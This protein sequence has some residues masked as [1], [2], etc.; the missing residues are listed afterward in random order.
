M[1]FVPVAEDTGLVVALGRQVL[2]RACADARRWSELRPDAPPLELAVNVSARELAQRD[3]AAYVARVLQET[4]LDPGTLVLEITET[5]LMGNIDRSVAALHR[6]RDLGVRIAVDD[7]GT[8][9]ASLGYLRR[10]PIDILKVEKSFI[11]GLGDDGD[12][13]VFAQAIVSLGKSL[14]LVVVAEGVET[15]AHLREIAAI[16]CDVAQ[17]YYFSRPI[18]GETILSVFAA[19]HW[20]DGLPV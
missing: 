16:G 15:E 19:P 18:D 14:G 7:F 11:Q 8:G 20:A 2:R 6:L 13:R 5:V 4:G 1:E 12:D 17:G 9:Y 10:L 3:Y